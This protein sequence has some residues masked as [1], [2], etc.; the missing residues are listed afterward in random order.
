M[1]SKEKRKS[2]MSPPLSI[3]DLY[4]IFW[5]SNFLTSLDSKYASCV[6]LGGGGEMY[7]NSMQIWIIQLS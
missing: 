2:D 7:A 5:F 6:I 1:Q 4:Y 3:Y